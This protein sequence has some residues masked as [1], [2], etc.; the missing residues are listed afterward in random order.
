MVYLADV[1]FRPAGVRLAAPVRAADSKHTLMQAPEHPGAR[2][3]ANPF[4]PRLKLERD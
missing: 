4:R 1:G 2:T 3:V